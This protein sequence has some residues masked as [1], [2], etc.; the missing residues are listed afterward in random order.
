[1]VR[2]AT[3]L[4]ILR[5]AD[6]LFSAQGV[7]TVSLDDIAEAAG[8][9]KRTIYYHFETKDRL[10]VE[11]LAMRSTETQMPV[12]PGDPAGEILALFDGLLR[13]IESGEVR[14]CPFV[15]TSAALQDAGHPARAV[16][17]RHKRQRRLWFEEKLKA[18]GSQRAREG[19]EE[20][21]LL[22]DGALAS[23]IL[24]RDGSPA[25]AAK[26]LAKRIVSSS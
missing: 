4:R 24:I 25:R 13:F 17:E 3:E 10:I 5:A 19:A 9:T 21:L 12:K 23:A 15:M 22:W 1:M 7:Q 16:A 8:V 26:R 11:W 20:L 6:G 18:N 14:G 2:K